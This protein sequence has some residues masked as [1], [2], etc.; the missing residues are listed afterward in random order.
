MLFFSFLFLTLISFRSSQ[1]AIYGFDD[2][3]DILMS[4][5]AIRPLFKSIAISLPNNFLTKNSDGTFNFAGGQKLREGGICPNQ[6]FVEQNSVSYSCTGFL[7]SDRLLVTAGHC[8]LPNGII[9]DDRNSPFCEA[10]SWYF[11][12]NTDSKGQSRLENIPADQ[13]YRCS[14]VLRAENLDGTSNSVYLP[15]NDFAVIELERAVS[16]SIPALKI[17]PQTARLGQSIF[18]I[19]HTSGLPAKFS[20]FST[21]HRIDN[22]YMG[23]FLDTLGGNSGGPVF[24]QKNEIVGIL[25]GGHPVDYVDSPNRCQKPNL[26]SSSGRN[27]V[28]ESQFKFLPTWSLIQPIEVIK[29]YVSY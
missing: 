29:S 7:I 21:I 15:G 17:S 9:N 20:G 16:T 23:S 19:G 4:P 11:G 18:T 14:R 28:E 25:V 10:F 2:R 5:V 27:C 22:P 8:L 24:N 6:R 13:V 3:K 12:Y 1:A 26:C